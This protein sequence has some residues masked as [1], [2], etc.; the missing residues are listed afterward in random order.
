MMKLNPFLAQLS[1]WSIE[2]N[3]IYYVLATN[4]KDASDPWTDLHMNWDY[5]ERD[6]EDETALTKTR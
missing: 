6:V 5:P 4:R 1:H 3:R 2:H